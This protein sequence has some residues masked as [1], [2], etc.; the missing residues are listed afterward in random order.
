MNS[1]RSAGKGRIRRSLEKTLELLTRIRS[2]LISLVVFVVFAVLS[3]EVVHQ[4]FVSD[5]F[6]VEPITVPAS[7]ASLGYSEKVVAGRF[8]DELEA[9]A[10]VA[11]TRKQ[12]SALVAGWR[13]PDIEVPGSGISVQSLA[14]VLA[15]GFGRGERKISGEVVVDDNFRLRLRVTNGDRYDV[16]DVQAVHIDALLQ[17]AALSATESI[18]PFLV[19]AYHYSRWFTGERDASVEAE[20]LRLLEICLSNDSK[21]D[22]AWAYNLKGSIYLAHQKYLASNGQYALALEVEPGF[23]PGRWNLA[24]VTPLLEASGNPRSVRSGA[25]ANAAGTRRLLQEMVLEDE[26]L[27][28]ASG[29]IDIGNRLLELGRAELSS[30]DREAPVSVALAFLSEARSI[31]PERDDLY[32]LTARAYEVIEEWPKALETYEVLA[33]LNPESK[34]GRESC[35]VVIE[36]CRLK[37]L[38]CAQTAESVCSRFQQ[39]L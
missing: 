29:L 38:E 4:A 3:F 13:M 2:Y 33:A 32:L 12:S 35:E 34:E 17:R 30:R 36:I 21:E 22:D 28:A 31:D 10:T 27:D 7:L 8:V 16:V 6:I 5:S 18:N 37:E 15:T 23:L 19:A 1:S 14:R 24:I 9:I 20:M 11:R 26:S 39:S 25:A